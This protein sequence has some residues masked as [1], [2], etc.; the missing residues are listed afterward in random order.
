MS[1]KA[2]VRLTSPTG[3][4]YKCQK[5]FRV[6]KQRPQKGPTDVRVADIY[7]DDLRLA[8]AT[9]NLA[10]I[11]IYGYLITNQDG[12]VGGLSRADI[13]ATMH[14][15]SKSYDNGIKELIE[16]GFFEFT[17]EFAT[18]GE[19][20]APLYNFYERPRQPIVKNT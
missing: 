4:L 6:I 2:I 5:A 16:K 18:D 11:R 10:A 8:L 3:K 12:Y 13:I 20:T 9:L 17:G 14:I 1:E 7:K 15:S 19:E